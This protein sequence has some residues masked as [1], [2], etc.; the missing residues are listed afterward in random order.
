M[1]YAYLD[2]SAADYTHIFSTRK[3]NLMKIPCGSSHNLTE[4]NCSLNL[5]QLRGHT[6]QNLSTHI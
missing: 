6:S 5:L 1:Y 3:H 2:S 4:I